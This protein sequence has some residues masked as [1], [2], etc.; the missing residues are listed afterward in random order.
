M[1]RYRILLALTCL[2]ICKLAVAAGLQWYNADDWD[3]LRHAHA[4]RPW[5]VH[6]WGMSCDPC[7]QEMA[8]WG[9]FVHDHPG[10]PVTFIEVEQA[11]PPEVRSVLAQGGLAGGDQWLS[12]DGF[13]AAQRYAIARHWG[14]EIPFTL[15][16]SPDGK[17]QTITGTMDFRRLGT[18]AEA[19][20]RR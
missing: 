6:L 12:A 11:A 14:G 16:I 3:A 13:D 20:N 4:S 18:W 19:Q 9:R 5:I 2:S 17:M 7:R 1:K 15:L 8:A 10:I